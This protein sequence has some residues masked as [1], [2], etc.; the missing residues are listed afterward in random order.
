MARAWAWA[1]A[2]AQARAR[3]QGPGPE[4]VW[5]MVPQARALGPGLGLGPELVRDMVLSM[6]SL[7]TKPCPAVLPGT[8]PIDN[9]VRRSHGKKACWTPPDF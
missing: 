3:A 4:L 2:R 1:Q 5:D 7:L 6:A 9:M 8:R